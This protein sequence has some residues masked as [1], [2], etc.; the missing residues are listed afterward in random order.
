MRRFSATVLILLTCAF[1][2]ARSAEQAGLAEDGRRVAREACAQCH[3]VAGAGKPEVEAP[4]FAAIAAMPSTTS[5]AIKVFLKTP[6]GAMPDLILSEG[7]ID[8]L[9]AYILSLRGQ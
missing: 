5:V 3:L 7:E 2:P 4:S 8:A 9:A 6:H 1:A